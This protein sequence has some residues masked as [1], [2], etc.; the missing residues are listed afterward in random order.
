MQLR[1][2]PEVLVKVD[3]AYKRALLDTG[4]YFASLVRQ[5]IIDNE[6]FDT[7]GILNSIFVRVSGDGVQVW[8]DAI[9]TIVMEFWRKPLSKRPP[10]QILVPWANRKGIVDWSRYEDLSSK[11]KWIIYVMAKSIGEKG[12]KPRKY[13]S[14]TYQEN[15][16]KI[17]EYF[18]QRFNLYSKK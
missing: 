11:D 14:E 2:H 10:S 17:Q 6:W 1:F 15:L 4:E 5:K 8:S 7:W 13:F 12:I 9:Q 3:R 18:V 16:T